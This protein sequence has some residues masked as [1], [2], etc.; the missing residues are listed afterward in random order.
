MAAENAYKYVYNDQTAPEIG[1]EQEQKQQQQLKRPS[2]NKYKPGSDEENARQDWKATVS[3]LRVMCMVSIVISIF[4][5]SVFMN[6]AVRNKAL[7]Y[8]RALE[9]YELC[10]QKSVELDARLAALNTLQNVDAYAVEV[11]GFVKSTSSN[12]E[13]LD[14]GENK[15]IFSAEETGVS[16]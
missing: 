2:L 16:E 1:V 9:K 10:V 11:L 15:V 8:E 12:E 5:G 14:A 7:E 4:I 3:V 6:G 13:Y